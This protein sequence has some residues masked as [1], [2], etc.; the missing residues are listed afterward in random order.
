ML[1]VRFARWIINLV[2]LGLLLVGALT[3][4]ASRWWGL[5][6][7]SVASGSME[8]TIPVGSV[9]AVQPVDPVTLRL[10]YII[11]FKSPENPNLI[12]THRVNKVT[13]PP[14]ARLFH[15]KGDAN[16]D[17]DLE[18]VPAGNVLGRVRFH[19]PYLGYLAQFVRT[20]RGWLYLVAVPAVLVVLMEL[21]NILKVIWTSHE[22]PS[23]E[24]GVKIAP[25]RWDS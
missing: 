7:R 12:V 20:P 22:Q 25:A 2:L 24:G 16:D 4:M 10:G 13:G 19:L 15:T 23:D 9:V 8:P 5:D 3:F 21:V 11:T 1:I 17:P 18:L 6:F 14:E